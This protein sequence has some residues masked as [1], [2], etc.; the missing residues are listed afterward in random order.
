MQISYED[1]FSV[2][3]KA[4]SSSKFTNIFSGYLH[5]VSFFRALETK[6]SRVRSSPLPWSTCNVSTQP[7]RVDRNSLRFIAVGSMLRKIIFC[8]AFFDFLSSNQGKIANATE[9]FYS[10]NIGPALRHACRPPFANSPPQSRRR[11]ILSGGRD[12]IRAGQISKC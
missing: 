5:L 1:Y 4:A 6:T 3:L 8:L 7:F 12:Q 9:T 10:L 2:A 11:R